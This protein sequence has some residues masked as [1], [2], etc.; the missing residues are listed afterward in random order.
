MSV[1]NELRRLSLSLYSRCSLEDGELVLENVERAVEVV[2][3]AF[4]QRLGL[5]IRYQLRRFVERNRDFYLSSS[6][7]IKISIIP[8]MLAHLSNSRNNMQF[9]KHKL[10]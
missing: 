10:E 4:I 2:N 9:V 6:D 5:R 8:N 3:D 1:S 7:R